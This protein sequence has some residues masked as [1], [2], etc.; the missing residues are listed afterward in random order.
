MCRRLA[1]LLALMSFPLT[2]V[3]AQWFCQGNGNTA[4]C[5]PCYRN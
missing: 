4:N 1:L 5:P 3:Q 2:V